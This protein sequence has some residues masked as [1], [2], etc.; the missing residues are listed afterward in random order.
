MIIRLLMHGRYLCATGAHY[1]KFPVVAK[2]NSGRGITSMQVL[3]E[4]FV[5]ATGK[6]P[7]PLDVTTAREE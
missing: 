7:K 2:A 3:Q 6:I 5:N 4:F 1:S